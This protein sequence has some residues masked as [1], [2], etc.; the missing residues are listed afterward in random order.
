MPTF[1]RFATWVPNEIQSWARELNVVPDSRGKSDRPLLAQM[2]SRDTT[3]L[4]Q[5]G[6]AFIRQ[7][8]KEPD[9]Q[10]KLES[11]LLEVSYIRK[12][13]RASDLTPAEAVAKMQEVIRVAR[14]LA[15]TIKAHSHLFIRDTLGSIYPNSAPV[16]RDAGEMNSFTLTVADKDA[17]TISEILDAFAEA[18]CHDLEFRR[19]PHDDQEILDSEGQLK[20]RGGPP[21][22]RS[23]G[24]NAPKN[25]VIR[26]ISNLAHL[27]LGAP[28]NSF[29]AVIASI[30]IGVPDGISLS[31]YR[32]SAVPTVR[33]GRLTK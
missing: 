12:P 9:W 16:P 23:D 22:G 21:L 14:S 25:K 11:F 1:Y 20:N 29:C 15:Q 27:H 5:H 2:L 3:S 31:T 7:F 32:D 6:K 24:D 33:K 19:Q 13:E 17:L 18:T 4:S 28:Y 26:R 8:K 30:V 10:E